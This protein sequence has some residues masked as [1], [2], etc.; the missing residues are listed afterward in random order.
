VD[1]SNAT[2]TSGDDDAVITLPAEA[3]VARIA[4]NTNNL[5][6]T[7]ATKLTV[8]GITTTTTGGARTLTLPAGT[9]TVDAIM[10]DTGADLTVVSTGQGGA[11]L[12]PASVRG[13]GALIL[14]DNTVQLSGNITDNGTI[15]LS[16]IGNLGTN[17]AYTQLSNITGEGAIVFTLPAGENLSFPAAPARYDITIVTAGTAGFAGDVAV[18]D[19]SAGAVT[20]SGVTLGIGNGVFTSLTT[21]GLTLTAFNGIG[22]TV[23]ID[24]NSVGTGNFSATG[25]VTLNN[26]ELYLDPT[27]TPPSEIKNATLT[28]VGEDAKI[29]S[30]SADKFVFEPG[31]YAFSSDGIQLQGDTLTLAGTISTTVSPLALGSGDQKLTVQGTSTGAALT[32]TGTITFKGAGSG[33]IEVAGTLTLEDNTG[34]ALGNG[35]VALTD[36][37]RLAFDGTTNNYLSGF[38]FNKGEYI[39]GYT[40]ETDSG[41]DEYSY[42]NGTYRDGVTITPSTAAYATS[43]TDQHVFAGGTLTVANTTTFDGKTTSGGVITKDSDIAR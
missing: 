15:A 38:T 3:S 13:G 25:D 34:I 42:I 33:L 43:Y 39:T 6:I 1:L 24:D 20:A 27:A 23:V 28:I 32:A 37:S 18:R 29:D 5:A 7:G 11:I 9:V 4:L 41:K 22:G 12:H 36:A 16:T 26:I 14:S 30:G 35:A 17:D 40:V 10:P 31:V 8:G 19:L 2:L 21:T